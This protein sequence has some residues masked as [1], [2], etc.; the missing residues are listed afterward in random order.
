MSHDEAT[1][2]D[3]EARIAEQEAADERATRM[4]KRV[5]IWSLVFLVVW[6]AVVMFTLRNG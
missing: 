3:H 2:V 4:L 1:Q 5:G 6:I